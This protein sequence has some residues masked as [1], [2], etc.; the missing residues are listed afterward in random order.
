MMRSALVE[1]LQQD[2]VDAARAKG[3]AEKMVLKK[4]VHVEMHSF[5]L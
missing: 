3:L 2:Y 1:E 4:H 5:R